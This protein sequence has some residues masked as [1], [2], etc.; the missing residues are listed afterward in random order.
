[1]TKHWQSFAE[2]RAV[3]RILLFF[4]SPRPLYDPNPSLCAVDELQSTQYTVQT[5]FLLCFV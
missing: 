4:R 5:Q 3:H 1:M 2:E